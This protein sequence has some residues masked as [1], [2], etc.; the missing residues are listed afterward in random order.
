MTLP[1]RQG[2]RTRTP[3]SVRKRLCGSG[4]ATKRDMAR[5]VLARYPELKVYLAQNRKWKERFHGNMFDL[6]PEN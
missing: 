6:P 4:R 3:S 5:A 1:T 2:A